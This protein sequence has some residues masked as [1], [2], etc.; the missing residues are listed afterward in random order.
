MKLPK[1]IK[2]GTYYSKKHDA[3]IGFD[4]NIEGGLCTIWSQWCA[5][6]TW[7]KKEGYFHGFMDTNLTEH[8][9][10]IFWGEYEPEFISELSWY[11]FSKEFIFPMM[12]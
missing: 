7:S 8:N 5:A 2:L 4:R 12:E 9:L 3:I 11:E 10:K 6:G 1:V